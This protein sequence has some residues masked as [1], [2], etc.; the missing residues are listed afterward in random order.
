M[1]DKFAMPTYDILIH[2]EIGKMADAVDKTLPIVV[3]AVTYH[4]SV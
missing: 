2:L 3:M 4:C 1:G